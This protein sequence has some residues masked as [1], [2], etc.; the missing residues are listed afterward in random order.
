MIPALTLLLFVACDGAGNMP[1][2]PPVRRSKVASVPAVQAPPHPPSDAE[3]ERFAPSWQRTLAPVL[4][5][6]ADDASKCR[7]E[8]S[9]LTHT[10]RAL[11][12]EAVRRLVAVL[13]SGATYW[14]TGNLCHCCPLHRV[15]IVCGGIQRDVLVDLDCGWVT[16]LD[17]R[18]NERALSK[19]GKR[20]LSELLL[21]P[22][23]H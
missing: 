8:V 6:A 7:G 13:N 11:S 12:S 2:R 23:A 3:V 19:D 14:L 5:V 22:G 21:S 16:P 17:D 10:G 20:D 15:R 9:L 4:P 1:Q 18:E